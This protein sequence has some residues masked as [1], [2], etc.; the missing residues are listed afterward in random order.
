MMLLRILVFNADACMLFE[1][2]DSTCG[3]SMLWTTTL[4]E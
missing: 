4:K 1:L 3:H 2:Q